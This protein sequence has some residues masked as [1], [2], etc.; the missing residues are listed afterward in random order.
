MYRA[1]YGAGG[2]VSA[3]ARVLRHIP[4]VDKAGGRY[5]AQVLLQFG[6]S[7]G[8]CPNLTL[9]PIVGLTRGLESLCSIIFVCFVLPR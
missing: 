1:R 9:I 4:G 3:T 5:H 2:L 6:I 8:V 7:F